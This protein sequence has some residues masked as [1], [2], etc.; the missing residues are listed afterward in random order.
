MNLVIPPYRLIR[1]QCSELEWRFDESEE[2]WKVTDEFDSVLEQGRSN[3]KLGTLLRAFL[4]RHP[5]H[6][7]ALTHYAMCKRQEGKTLDAYAFAR[8]A[9]A[10][11]KEA[12]PR[13][14]DANL[15]Q[16]PGGF[17]ENRPFLRALY[18]LM[19]CCEALGNTKGAAAIGFEILALDQEDRMGARYELPKYLILE[20]RYR[21]AAEL[22]EKPEFD[23][24]FHRAFYLYPLVLLYLARREEAKDAIESCLGTPQTARYLLD[25]MLAMP[26]SDSF[27]GGFTS[28]SELEGYYYAR[29]YRR[30]WLD[31]GDAVKLLLKASKKVEKAGWPRYYPVRVYPT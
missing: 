16:I 7:D 21:A 11:A 14:F 24:T 1:T 19:Q 5:W 31:C 4:K 9:V 10:T 8:T 20:G 22:F 26:E 23:G 2:A 12:I 18:E 30:F 25:P 27:L 15:H 17:V 28:G 6:F 3:G 13:D 29:Q